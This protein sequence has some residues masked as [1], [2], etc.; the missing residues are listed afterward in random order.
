MIHGEVSSCFGDEH[1]R[2]DAAHRLPKNGGC[3]SGRDEVNARSARA[4]S[5]SCPAAQPTAAAAVLRPALVMSW[6]CE[7]AVRW[8]PQDGRPAPLLSS[9]I[10][11]AAVGKGEHFPRTPKDVSA[12]EVEA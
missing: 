2:G 11:L 4:G 5:R 6:M 3:G 10:G 9:V 7:P 12:A 8:P 1:V